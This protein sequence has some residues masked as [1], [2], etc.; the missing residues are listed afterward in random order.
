MHWPL[1]SHEG[2]G[3]YWFDLHDFKLFLEVTRQ[4]AVLGILNIF[5]R[6]HSVWLV[7]LVKLSMGLNDV[8]LNTITISVIDSVGIDFP[9]RTK[10]NVKVIF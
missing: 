6:E 3:V 2:I 8:V 4:V 9:L 7:E 5:C 10:L 1:F